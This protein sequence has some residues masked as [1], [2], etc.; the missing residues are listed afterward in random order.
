[1]KKILVIEDQSDVREVITELLMAEDFE[2][3]DAANGWIG[4]QLAQQEMPDLIL[5]DVMMPE[6]DGYGV[7]NQLRQ[8]P[9]TEAIP[10]IFLTAKADKSSLRQGME[11][12]AD[13]Y[14]TKPFT[15]DE[16]LGA[17]AA[18]EG[19]QVITNR[20]S[21]QKLNELRGN[22]THSLPHELNTPLN[23]ILGLS[24]FLLSD[25]DSIDRD[26]ALEM[27]E[28]IY[29]SG[30]RLY[31]LTQNFLL[32]ADLELIATDPERVKAL[33]NS[34]ETSQTQSL[35]IDIARQKAKQVNRD[36]DLRL[37]LQESVAR[38][39][40]SKL[41][42]IVEEVVDNA[43]KFS[44]PNTPVI[45]RSSVQTDTVELS[46]VNAGRGMTAEQITNLGAYR[47]FERKLYEQQGSGLGLT[48][49]KRL[50][51][52]H[53]GILTVK[54]IPNQETILCISLPRFK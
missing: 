54:S 12:G 30:E 46:V 27:L 29:T 18:R 50:T 35:I 2:V 33:Q 22:L 26:E 21:Q 39:S 43:F 42:K 44:T 53:G 6:L 3:I 31:R 45:L 15:R 4:V 19:K 14:L 37:E 24:Q 16:L 8:N 20:Q 10:F 32:Y 28:A 1:M 11:L 48:I 41:R 9:S 25:Y 36:A 40:E 13:D 23:A 52:L 49:A 5:C 7:I 47:Q 51:E 38:I 17:I 34:G